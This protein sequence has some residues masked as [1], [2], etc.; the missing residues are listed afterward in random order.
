MAAKIKKESLVDQI[1]QRLREDIITQ[2]I[3]L[4]TR[5]NVNELQSQLGVSCTPVREAVNRLQQEGLV[6]YENN[7]GASVLTLDEHDIR[8]IDELAYTLQTAAVRLAMAHGDREQMLLEIDEQIARYENARNPRENV[9]AVYELIGVFYHHC[10]NRR[11]DESM[12]ALQG[13]VLLLRHIYAECPGAGDNVDLFQRMREGVAS[14]D[15]ELIYAAL[16]EYGDRMRPAVLE[17]LESR[18]EQGK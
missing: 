15:K 1:H 13:Q 2:R 17:W 18:R 14:G 10:G 11:L 16:R 8:E 12:I 7:V 6:I 3:P 9:K 4:G 5:L